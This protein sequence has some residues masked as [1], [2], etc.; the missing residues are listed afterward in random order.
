MKK[1]T[2]KNKPKKICYLILTILNI[3]APF[4]AVALTV[5][6]ETK[7]TVKEQI[8]VVSPSPLPMDVLVEERGDL[9]IHFVKDNY[10]IRV[11]KR[12]DGSTLCQLYKDDK[13]FAWYVP[14]TK[15]DR[16]TGEDV[17]D[18]ETIPQT[19]KSFMFDNGKSAW[20]YDG[21][22]VYVKHDDKI[23][24]LSKKPDSDLTYASGYITRCMPSDLT[25]VTE[26]KV[27]DRNVSNTRE[28]VWYI[29]DRWIPGL[30]QPEPFNGQAAAYDENLNEGYVISRYKHEQKNRFYEN[31]DEILINKTRFISLP[32]G[33]EIT[34]HLPY[35]YTAPIKDIT[36]NGKIYNI[37]FDN[38]DD[39]IKLSTFAKEIMEGKLNTADG[40]F[41]TAR[42][43]DNDRQYVNFTPNFPVDYIVG[44]SKDEEYALSLPAN[45]KY[46]L[47][48][49]AE[50]YKTFFPAATIIENA[51]NIV[52]PDGKGVFANSV[53][54][55]R[56][57]YRQREREQGPAIFKELCQTYYNKYGQKYVDAAL[58]GKL[59]IGTPE[60][61]IKDLYPCD[62]RSQDGDTKVYLI[63][64][65]KAIHDKLK[66][67]I[68]TEY[69]NP[70]A[71]K[72]YLVTVKNGVVTD[73]SLD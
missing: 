37:L 2:F 44:Y 57:E 45:T 6:E 28:I 70:Y 10:K 25:D 16:Y 4:R 36:Q 1:T 33:E 73:F 72:F 52:Q 56:D 48:I 20:V 12:Q 64:F 68:T 42:N 61:M 23:S 67:K 47:A 38:E 7:A 34:V 63:L 65:D 24:F 53:W 27:L 39:F 32:G 69:K 35:N 30:A 49:K 22:V 50:N 11:Y 43:P 8:P 60:A 13:N 15:V 58:S 46:S 51:N 21:N 19:L 17:D 5:N 55:W 9:D 54:L 66:K 29:N 26:R 62:L 31:A 18:L 14:N 59:L 40:V 3:I 41:T 71:K